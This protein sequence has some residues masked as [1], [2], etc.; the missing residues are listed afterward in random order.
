M[1]LLAST[2]AGAS[3]ATTTRVSLKTGGGQPNGDSH[4]PSPS[5]DNQRVVFASDANNLVAGDTNRGTDI[6]VRNLRTGHTDAVSVSTKGKLSNGP[7]DIGPHA[8]S[9]NGRYVA[10]SSQ[11]SNLVPK[12][13]NGVG[14]C[15][16]R[17]LKKGSTTLV[18]LGQGGKQGNDQSYGCRLTDDGKTVVFSSFASNL[19]PGDTNDIVDVFVRNLVTGAVSRVSVTSTG[20]QADNSSALDD[21]T[22]DGRYVVVQSWADNLIAGDT[23]AAL[24]VYVYDR[25]ARTVERA[26]VSSD[27]GQASDGGEFATI[28]A[29]GHRVA[30][31]TFSPLA[32]ADTNNVQDIYVRDLAQHT[33]YFVSRG[34]SGQVGDGDSVVATLDQH[35]N[36]V[37]FSSYADNLVP[38]DVNGS[39]DVFMRT[40]GVASSLRLISRTPAGAPADDFSFRP[41]LSKDGKLI[42]YSSF[43][44]DLVPGDTNGVEDAFAWHA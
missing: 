43:A 44:D 35:G 18:S 6:F 33:T 23:N 31:Q 36:L 12:D 13:N 21:M 10:F 2:A 37:T 11:G 4:F 15:F 26:S 41:V 1:V 34:D 19:V 30:F 16:V 22:A 40:V 20:G 25:T 8:I 9:S 5:A 42:T 32:S 27:G 3:T 29:D 14:D 24:D 7:S 39:S 38:G 28:S 17:D